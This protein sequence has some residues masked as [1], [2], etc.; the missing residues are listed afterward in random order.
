MRGVNLDGVETRFARTARGGDEGR[1]DAADAGFVEFLR[2][3]IT[4]A[5]G[6]RRRRH[7]RP[8]AFAG[9][10]RALWLPAEADAGLAAG[11]SQLHGDRASLLAREARDRLERFGVPVVPEAEV[12][13]AD[14]AFGKH[15][16]RLDDD[17]ARTTNGACAVMDEMPVRGCAVVGRVLAH[18]RYAD[19]VGE[20]DITQLEFGEQVGHG[21]G[22][23]Q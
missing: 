13:R 18:G 9:R 12:A 8:A 5:E 16:R 3:G 15:R 1:D 11:M 17:Q 4:F 6:K 23:G 14:A 22:L 21:H 19:A 20:R 10:Q 7:G 2:H